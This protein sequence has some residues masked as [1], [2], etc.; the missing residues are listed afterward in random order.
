MSDRKKNLK[1]NNIE[2]RKE[3]FNLA[4]YD[5]SDF[6]RV[7]SQT[8]TTQNTSDSSNTKKSSEE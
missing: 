7:L 8:P 4:S 1:Q 5:N 6:L 2:I 3:Q